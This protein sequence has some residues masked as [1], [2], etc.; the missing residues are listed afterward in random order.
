VQIKH[1]TIPISI[2]FRIGIPSCYTQV[3]HVLIDTTIVMRLGFIIN[4][5]NDLELGSDPGHNSC[6]RHVPGDSF[7][8]N[9]RLKR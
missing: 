2:I 3:T 9:S 8:F 4:T 1:N 7:D 6:R 5:T